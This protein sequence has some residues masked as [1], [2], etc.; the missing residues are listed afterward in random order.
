MFNGLKRLHRFEKKIIRIGKIGGKYVKLHQFGFSRKTKEGFRFPIH[1]VQIGKDSA[2]RKNPVGLIAGVHGLETIGIQVLL[3]FMEYIVNPKS[4]GYIPEIKSGKVGILCLPIA[5]PGGVALKR[6]ANPGG[7]DLMRNSGID[8]EHPTPFFGGHKLTRRLPYFRGKGL[9][10]ESRSL[11]RLMA[12]YF[13]PITKTVLPVLDVHSGFG[14][15]DRVWWPYAK[16]DTFCEDQ[17]AYEKVADY[18]KNQCGHGNL[19][20]GSQSDSYQANGDL[21][22]LVY[23]QFKGVQRAKDSSLL[24]PFTLE[25]GTWSSIKEEPSRIFKKKGIFNPTKANRQETITR[26]RGF[27]RDYVMLSSTKPK[28][29]S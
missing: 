22:D 17:S 12:E 14:A 21:W 6:R 18:L 19:E 10:P 11:L 26:Y 29:W 15:I 2:I 23:D 27:L 9:Q 20:Y 8:A 5:N 1:M 13:Y 25:I 24:L 4:S 7:V 16:T 3:D 28:N